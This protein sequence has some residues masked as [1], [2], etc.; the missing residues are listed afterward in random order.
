MRF[1]WALFLALLLSGCGAQSA[2][3]STGPSEP[4]A[5]LTQSFY[6]PGSPM[7]TATNGAV[8]TYPLELPNVYGMKALDGDLLVLSLEDNTSVHILS[9]TELVPTAQRQLPFLLK[10]EDPS[11]RIHGDTFSYYDPTCQDVLVLDKALNTVRRISTPEDLVGT[12]LLSDDGNTLYYCTKDALRA[13]DLE[14]GIRRC[15]KDMA[16]LHQSVT[17]L[18]LD[19]R[20]IECT[21]SDGDQPRTLFLDA[22]TGSLLKSFDGTLTLETLEDRYY[23]AFPAGITQ[24]LVFGSDTPTA[25]TFR[26]LTA[27]AVILP[28]LDGAVSVFLTEQGSLRLEYYRLEEGLRISSLEWECLRRPDA[29]VSAGEDLYILV[30]DDS[31]EKHVIYRWSPEALPAEDDAVYTG[32]YYTLIQPDID[33]LARCRIYANLIGQQ[34]GIQIRI[35]P[36]AVANQPWDYELEPEYLVPVLEAELHLLEQRLAQY[37]QGVLQDTAAHFSS[38]TISLVRGIRGS[39]ESGSLEAATGIQFFDGSD[40]YVVIA[41]GRYGG[42]ALYHELFHVMET[43]LLT[44]PTALD[45]WEE[46]NPTGFRYDYSYSSNKNRDAGIY[47]QPGSRAFVDTYSMSFPKEDKARVMEYAMLPGMGPLF[48]SEIMQAKLRCLSDGLREAYGLQDR[49]EAF[50]W[51]QYLE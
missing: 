6:E 30:F 8:L 48:R 32:P 38:L 51:E 2:T 31:Y 12:P 9:G 29:I 43:H 11:L 4:E 23:A 26:D 15:V 10:A 19:G 18:H 5:A 50:L 22:E 28:Q 46:L 35:G 34:N 24:A 44:R 17:G 20:V 42:Q 16:I 25:L 21:V 41:V 40:A 3:L 7:E 39:P 1:L 13:W 45:R 14:T 27:E 47:L 37:P 36:D 33:G 49:E